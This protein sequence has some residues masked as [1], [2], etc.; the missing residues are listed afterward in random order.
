MNVVMLMGRLTKD[1][2]IKTGETMVARYTLAVDRRGEGTDFVPCVTFGKRAE[3]AQKFLKRG[4]KI[5]VTGRLQ[6]GSYTNKDGQKVNTTDV[7]VDEHE[8]CEPKRKE[9]DD[10]SNIP[11]GI[12]DDIFPRR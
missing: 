1:P 12:L 6:T 8:F 11:D 5:A 10:F 7:I 2:E 9:S 4:I 3:F